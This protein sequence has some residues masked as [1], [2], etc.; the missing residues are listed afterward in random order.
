MRC[1]TPSPSP[2]RA[3]RALSS[4]DRHGGRECARHLLGERHHRRIEPP[5]PGRRRGLD[6]AHDDSQVMAARIDGFSPW[7]RGDRATL[8]LRGVGLEPTTYGLTVRGR[9]YRVMPTRAMTCGSVLAG[10]AQLLYLRERFTPNSPQR[11]C[12][13]LDSDLLTLALLEEGISGAL[14]RLRVH[15]PAAGS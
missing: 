13:T 10:R 6:R 3:L 14:I 11:T 1:S 15:L 9:P 8:W 7:G 4:P 2:S 5:E 12:P